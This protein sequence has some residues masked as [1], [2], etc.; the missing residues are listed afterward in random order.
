MASCPKLIRS[1]GGENQ[2]DAT[3]DLTEISSDN[4]FDSDSSSDPELDSEV[5]DEDE[6][7][8]N[9]FDDEGQLPP[10]HYLAQAESLD[11]TQLQQKRYSDGTQERLDETRMYW[12]RYCQHIGVDPAQHW[13]WISDSDE[14][15][16]FLYAFFGWRCNI[17]CGK[18]GRHC[19]GI[20]YKSSLESFWKW[21]HLVLK[22]ETV[23]GLS[24]DITI[25]VNDVIAMVAKEKGLELNQQLKKNM[26]IEDVAEFARVLLTTTEMT[27]DCS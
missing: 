11:V 20:A 23:S 25:K 14:T 19:P 22:Q 16:C 15:V 24:K 8:N 5:S 9:A 1:D 27:F 13:Q 3:S 17:C 21:W 12:N 26:Y 18:N 4:G 6:P 2:S 7:D 10:E